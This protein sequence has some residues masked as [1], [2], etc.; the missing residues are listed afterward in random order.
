VTHRLPLDS[1]ALA[2]DL[3]VAGKDALKILINP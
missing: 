3:A 2:F 1:L